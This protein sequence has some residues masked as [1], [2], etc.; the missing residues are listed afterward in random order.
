MEVAAVALA[1]A[2]SC[3]WGVA[4]FLG[5]LKSRSLPLMAVLVLSQIAGLAL[6]LGVVAAVLLRA[7]LAVGWRQAP[8]LA[9]IGVLDSGANA[10]YAGA[11]RLGMISLVA[12]LASLYPVVTVALARV[13]LAE[14]LGLRARVGVAAALA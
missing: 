12:V 14:R 13:F 6:M 3:S 8:A 4:D 1:L 9:A 7:R 5:G 2:A 10:L 11:G